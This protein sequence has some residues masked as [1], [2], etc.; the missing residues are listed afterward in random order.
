MKNVTI[1]AS[2]NILI[3]LLAITALT[4]WGNNRPATNQQAAQND[5]MSG[6]H[7][8]STPANTSAF[9]SLKGKPAPDFTL[10]DY[11]GNKVTL[12]A[13]KGKKVILFFNEGLMC[14]PACW[15]QIAAF[16]RGDELSGKGVVVFNI[17]KENRNDWKDAVKKMPDLAKA[18]VLFDTTA[19][20]SS[21]YGVLTLPSSMHKGQYPGHTYFIV[22]P[23]GVIKF[24]QD[25]PQMAVRNKELTAEV[26]KI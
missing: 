10:E 5:D 19:S 13:L 18:T 14:Y 22:G 6:H 23:D 17:V 20:V 1:F 12:S 25:D 24:A 2:V 21:A 15:N 9:D 16:G 3:V 26:D 7:G 8:G 11:S 4:V